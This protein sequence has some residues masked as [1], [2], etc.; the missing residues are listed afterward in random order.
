M[1]SGS[2][3]TATVA[4]AHSIRCRF[5]AR[6]P[7]KARKMAGVLTRHIAFRAVGSA[8]AIKLA[9]QK[10]L[11]H[12]L[13]PLLHKA[14]SM[15]RGLA[16]FIAICTVHQPHYA[17]WTRLLCRT[18]V[19]Y[20]DARLFASG[21]AIPGSKLLEVRTSS[22]RTFIC[23]PEREMKTATAC[24]TCNPILHWFMLATGC[25]R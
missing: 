12:V 18:C 16:H 1:S 11:F 9:F 5:E 25:G 21:T 3:T 10:A 8:P 6:G 2:P 17:A 7:S 4:L 15:A 19:L 24:R 13:S 14:F 22:D 20:G 23:G